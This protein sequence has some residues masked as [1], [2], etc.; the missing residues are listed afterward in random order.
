[1]THKFDT[2]DIEEGD[3]CIYYNG[4]EL[5]QGR[6]APCMNCGDWTEW[7]DHLA[8]G[9]LCSRECVDEYWWHYWK[10]A[11]EVYDYEN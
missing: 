9:H 11:R 2:Y 5:I 7:I 4:S 6:L 10:A 1:M 3:D 8:F